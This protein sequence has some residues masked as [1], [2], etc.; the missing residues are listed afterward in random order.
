MSP[1]GLRSSVV[2]YAALVI[3][4]ASPEVVDA[5]AEEPPK[6]WAALEFP[7]VVELATQSMR[8]FEKTPFWG[9][10]YYRT[11]RAVADELLAFGASPAAV[12]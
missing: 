12:S 2:A 6:H 1:R 9:A 3:E 4:D 8:Y 7:I 11:T 10:A 5:V